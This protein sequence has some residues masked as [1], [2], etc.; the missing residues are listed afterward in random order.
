VF[1]DRVTGAYLPKPA[2]TEIVRHTLVKDAM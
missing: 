2:R 1:G